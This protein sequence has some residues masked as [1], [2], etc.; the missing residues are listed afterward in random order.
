VL[1][2]GQSSDGITRSGTGFSARPIGEGIAGRKG[3]GQRF[4]PPSKIRYG[5]FANRSDAPSLFASPSQSRSEFLRLHCW[6]QGCRQQIMAH[7]LPLVYS[8]QIVRL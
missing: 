7:P 6:H 3:T 8:R 1:Y 5:Q 2:V 4:A